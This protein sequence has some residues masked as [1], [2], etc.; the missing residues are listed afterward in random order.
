MSLDKRFPDFYKSWRNAR[1]SYKSYFA[2]YGGWRAVIYSV[3]TQIALLLGL[4]CSMGVGIRFGEIGTSVLPNLLG[5][6]IGA[7]AIVLSLS[8]SEFFTFLAEKGS[9]NSYFLKLVSNFLHYIIAQALTIIVCVIEKS[10]CANSPLNLIA[11]SLFFFSVM[12]PVAMGVQLF[13]LAKLYNRKAY[14]DAAHN[15][16]KGTDLQ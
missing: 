6:T 12:S 14:V 11:S 8:T 13:L 9:S 16:T 1:G 5:F 2:I 4:L 3:Y 7:M 15:N 10:L